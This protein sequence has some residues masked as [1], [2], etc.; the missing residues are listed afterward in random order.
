MYRSP[1][2]SC[3]YPIEVFNRTP[4]LSYETT[5]SHI[6]IKHVHGVVDGLDLLNLWRGG[7]G[8]EGGR[9]RERKRE[10][11]RERGGREREEER[12][13]ECYTVQAMQRHMLNLTSRKRIHVLFPNIA[14]SQ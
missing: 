14:L 11:K 9:E 4:T 5:L 13:R 3:L 6:K 10:E 8:R 2:E 7:R 12:M 1:C